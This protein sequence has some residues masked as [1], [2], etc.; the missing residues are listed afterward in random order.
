MT[1]LILYSSIAYGY[2]LAVPR[3]LQRESQWEEGI[4]GM[5]NREGQPSS[6]GVV[7]D[8]V[9]ERGGDAQ[10]GLWREM[11]TI[12]KDTEIL[13]VIDADKKMDA[14][15]IDV[16]NKHSWEKLTGLQ[17]SKNQLSSRVLWSAL[18]QRSA[19]SHPLQSGTLTSM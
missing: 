7:V 2:I 19:W 12:T 18:K 3:P 10:M 4:G 8:T 17:L 15:K 9:K 13:A 1:F 5:H 6:E 14:K 16:A 11:D